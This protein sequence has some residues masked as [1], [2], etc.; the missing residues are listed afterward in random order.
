MTQP[1]SDPAPVPRL[2]DRLAATRSERFVGR[3]RELEA[4]AAALQAA[5]PS[6]AV[7]Y[8][9]GPGGV[10]KTTLLRAYERLATES[11]RPVLLLDG[12]DIDATPQGF[13]LALRHLLGL[14]DD[15][16]PLDALVQSPRTL[17]LID[18]YENLAALDGWLR[19]TL[20]PALPAQI[21][22]VIAGRNAPA[23]AWRADP[24]WSA[25]TR[26]VSLRN[27]SPQ[28]SRAYL[29][30]RQVGETQHEAVLTF[31]HGHPLA[32]AL[33]ADL[34]AG[35]EQTPFSPE[36]APD[37]VRALL[38]RFVEQV[39]TTSHRR[40]LE[41]C[42]RTRVTTEALLAE[43]LGA[44]DAPA[45][46]SWLRELSFTEQGPEGLFPHNLAR[47][48]LD[49]DLRWRDPE[50]FRE[51]H[52][53]ILHVLVRRLQ[54]CTGREQQR[55]Y[56]D[57]VYLSRH[58]PLMRSYYDWRTMGTIFAE[59][60][61]PEDG[62]AILAM[63]RRHEGE[64]AAAIATTWLG[65]RPDAFVTFRD[66]GRQ[67]VGFTTVLLLDA[68]DLEEPAFDPVVA[69]VWRHVRSSGPLRQGERV[70]LHRFW[71]NAEGY[72]DRAAVTLAATVGGIRWLTTPALAWSFLVVANPDERQSHFAQIGFPRLPEA[73]FAIG[74][75]QFGV[76]AHDWRREPPLTWIERKG[77][78]E[79]AEAAA[80]APDL[81]SREPLVAL[82]EPDFAQAV[83]QALRDFTRPA[84]LVANPLLR[85]R[86]AVER[87]AKPT[88]DT[89][90]ALLREAVES[91]RAN[92]RD[93][94]LYRALHHTY[95]EPAASQ[96][97]AAEL[98][99]LPFSTYRYHL[100]GGIA[101]VTE[102]LWQRELHGARE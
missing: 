96:E 44:A 43:V 13:L 59:P 97:L 38:E 69:A 75:R 71:M 34:V 3:E 91:L 79:M 15:V 33:V 89:L 28:E 29:Q 94:K 63:V 55:A 88:P 14:A 95:V 87:A 27:L 67:L 40:A 81:A 32:L 53:R 5:E 8:I 19:E 11:G 17:L 37:V 31:T 83:R 49:A 26:V 1:P 85:S 99:G 6:P 93:Q 7:L 65:R 30:A 51:L 4:F 39:P 41:V 66:T 98:L 84:A 86:L 61:T 73:V 2:A 62:A 54:Q 35:R 48:V 64:D 72:Q 80:V 74:G 52:R 20:L 101:R 56:F 90:Q 70:M 25:V 23:A 47:E 92:P 24:G 57:L 21:F 76:F 22:V 9:Y 58:N 68:A 60:A 78:L 77:L 82:S 45:L 10:G 16:S 42:A 102:W 100:S 18:S 36:Q 50:G 12:R 46:F